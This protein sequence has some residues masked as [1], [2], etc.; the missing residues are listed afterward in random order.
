M[1]DVVQRYHKGNIV[2]V[3]EGA[4]LRRW[5]KAIGPDVID[6]EAASD[7]FQE[8]G[9]TGTDPFG[10]TTTVVEAGAGGTSESSSAPSS[11]SATSG[12]TTLASC[13]RPGLSAEPGAFPR[14]EDW[15]SVWG[16]RTSPTS[17]STR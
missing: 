2:F 3:D 16:S 12:R 13:R 6:Y 9:A 4:H 15:R 10:W 5:V 14:P 1:T 8:N 7:Q 17:L 11:S